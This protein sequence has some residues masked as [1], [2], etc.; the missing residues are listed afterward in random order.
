MLK[1]KTFWEKNCDKEKINV[2]FEKQIK[3][4][5]CFTFSIQTRFHLP[6]SK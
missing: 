2:N 4:P 6:K 1:A 3:H 5:K